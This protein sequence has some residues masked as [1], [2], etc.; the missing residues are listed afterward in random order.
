MP[1]AGLVLGEARPHK[2]PELFGLVVIGRLGVGRRHGLARGLGPVAGFAV[3]KG[4]LLRKTAVGVA[5]P[6]QVLRQVRPIVA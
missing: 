5:E 2:N 1:G 3:D 4:R 6:L